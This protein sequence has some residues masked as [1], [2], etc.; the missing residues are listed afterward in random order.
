MKLLSITSQLCISCLVI[1]QCL[2]VPISDTNQHPLQETP[3]AR[4]GPFTRKHR[5]YYDHKVDA[6]G[7]GL[8]PLPWRNGEGASMMGPRNKAREQQNPDMVRPPNTDHGDMANLRWS[9]ADSHIR[10]EVSEGKLWITGGR[11][12]CSLTLLS[13]SILNAHTT[14]LQS[15]G[16]FCCQTPTDSW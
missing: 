11:R 4:H 7:E 2:A 16:S 3:S 13:T 9:F 6:G 10:I 15:H 1:G 14:L 5:D 8:H 12:R